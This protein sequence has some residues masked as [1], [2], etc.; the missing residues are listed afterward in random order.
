[1]TNDTTSISSTGVTLSAALAP[2]GA[3]ASYHFEYGKTTTYDTTTIARTEAGG[4]DSTTVTAL[5]AGLTPR[6]TY[7]YRV[8]ATNAD[9]TSTGADRTFS[10]STGEAG[11]SPGTGPG[12][13]GAPRFLSSRHS[14]AGQQLVLCY[15]DQY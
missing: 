12:G 3:Q 1:M 11:G 8:V 5:L 13:G 2:N 14:S 4:L 15:K 7:H 10:T 6:T 9:G